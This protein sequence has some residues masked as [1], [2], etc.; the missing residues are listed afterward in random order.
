MIQT[1]PGITLLNDDHVDFGGKAKESKE[2]YIV[3]DISMDVGAVHNLRKD[4][5]V[6]GGT[7]LSFS[8]A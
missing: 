2:Q 4:P 8:S 7:A 5:T 1:V 3:V 6:V